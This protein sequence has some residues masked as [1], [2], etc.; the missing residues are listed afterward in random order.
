MKSNMSNLTITFGKLKFWIFMFFMMCG[1]FWKIQ[2]T[3]S[4]FK[5]YVCIILFWMDTS[6][7]Y[8]VDFWIGLIVHWRRRWLKCFYRKHWQNI[9]EF[10]RTFYCGMGWTCRWSGIFGLKD[11]VSTEKSLSETSATYR[12]IIEVFKKN[13]V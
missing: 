8:W 10:Y 2:L 7:V 11:F 4:L 9:G 12:H 3:K 6:A 1:M 5:F 13:P